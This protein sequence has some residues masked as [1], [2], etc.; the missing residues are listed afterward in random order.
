MTIA[1]Q[2]ISLAEFLKLPENKPA[3]EYI[4]DVRVAPDWTID[5]LSPEQSPNRVT[6]NILHCIRYGCQL[7][8]L[9]DPGDRSILAFLPDR[10]PVLCEGSDIIPVPDAISLDLTSDL[11]F[12][13]LKMRE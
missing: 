10:Q 9:V 7:G 8:W 13:W 6:G 3:S 11:V 5:I 4:D 2:P 1:T 12:S